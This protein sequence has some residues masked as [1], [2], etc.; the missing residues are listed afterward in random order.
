MIYITRTH[1]PSLKNYNKYLK[2]IWESNWLT[3][4][5]ELV[6]ELEENLKAYWKVKNVVCVSSGTAAL[7]VALK[8]L[9]ITRK[10]YVS[11]NSFVS[12]VSAPLFLGIKPKF[13][14]LDE[15]PKNPAIVTHLYGIPQIVKIKPVIYD[16]SH[17]FPVKYKGKFLVSYGDISIVSF[18]AVKIFQTGEGGA[19]ITNNDKLA[20]KARLIRNFGWDGRYIIKG[21]GVNFKMSEFHA[22]M[23]LCNL[24]KI[25]RIFEKY[26]KIAS[27]YNKYLGY[28]HKDMTYYPVWYSSEEKLLKAVK[29]FEENG[30]SPRRYFYPP[31]NKIFGGKRCPIAE[32]YMS[33]VLCFPFY[34]DLKNDEIQK[35]IK[36][37]EETR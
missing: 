21:I 27:I 14:D 17:A 37:Y 23:G 15:D 3:N 10:I 6:K 24:P 19:V 13:Y 20:E 11:P 25:N 36:I 29:R 31:L 12:T 1:L 35:I 2:R 7:L 22:A 16:A 33:R 8:A 4:D 28:N 32:N 26:N 5:G 9:N 18:H 30:I 34:Y